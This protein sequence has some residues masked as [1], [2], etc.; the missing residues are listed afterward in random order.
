M[1]CG[2][3]GEPHRSGAR[4][5]GA[6]VERT[7]V[8]RMCAGDARRTAPP[9][10]RECGY[11]VVRCAGCASIACFNPAAFS[12]RRTSATSLWASVRM[13][14]VKRVMVSAMPGA[15]ARHTLWH[16]SS[17]SRRPSA[18]ARKE[19]AHS[20]PSWSSSAVM[21]MKMRAA[22]SRSS[23]VQ[24]WARVVGDRAGGVDVAGLHRP[25]VGEG[26]GDVGRIH[27]GER[28]GDGVLGHGWLPRRRA[29]PLIAAASK[30]PSNCGPVDRARPLTGEN[31]PPSG[32]ITMRL[33]RRGFPRPA[34]HGARIRH[35]YEVKGGTG[36]P[37]LSGAPCGEHRRRAR[38]DP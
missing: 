13:F 29:A 35:L 8:V 15:P 23:R 19:W 4:R 34:S 10:S 3:A 9:P 26:V 17:S 18:A 1:R 28:H 33:R 12:W 30:T 38:A 16:R 22:T 31:S 5:C 6:V 20:S 2:D 36:P 32:L 7:T 24:L 21:G 37:H 14:S 25:D 27:R 11:A